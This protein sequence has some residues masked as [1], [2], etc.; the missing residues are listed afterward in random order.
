[1]GDYENPYI[2]TARFILDV[3]SGIFRIK[4]GVVTFP[5]F[6]LK[7][8]D[9]LDANYAEEV[10][11]LIKIRRYLSGHTQRWEIEQPITVIL[12]ES[13]KQITEG[14][15]VGCENVREVVLPEGSQLNRIGQQ[16]F[17]DSGLE[18]IN[19]D[20]SQVRIIRDVCFFGCKIAHITLP[21]SLVILENSVFQQCEDLEELVV[22]DS[23]KRIGDECFKECIFLSKID[24]SRTEVSRINEGCFSG[25]GLEEILLPE[26]LEYIHDGAFSE[27]HSLRSIEIPSNVRYI[28]TRVFSNC[29]MLETFKVTEEIAEADIDDSWADSE[30]LLEV[31][32]DMGLLSAK[33]ENLPVEIEQ[34]M[35]Y[36]RLAQLELPIGPDVS[37]GTC[38]VERVYEPDE[39]GGSQRIVHCDKIKKPVVFATLTGDEFE[40]NITTS[41]LNSSL[42]A[43]TVIQNQAAM[44]DS[45]KSNPTIPE[46]SVPDSWDMLLHTEDT[47]RQD[48]S[49]REFLDMAL[50]D[51]NFDYSEPIMIA[52]IGEQSPTGEP[53]QLV[54]TPTGGP[55]PVR[56]VAQSMDIG[57][58]PGN[59]T[60]IVTEATPTPPTPPT[61]HSP[62]MEE[63]TM[64]GKQR[65]RRTRK[66]HRNRRTRRKQNKRRSK[67]RR[68]RNTKRK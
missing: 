61:P 54:A 62:F 10:V 17:L 52:W 22:P 38:R 50:N 21:E 44:N 31:T 58:P 9:L 49:I 11:K 28:G 63:S 60:I 1:M 42:K 57:G 45:T 53:V 35:P 16:A 27:C 56:L 15:F 64:L 48:I 34:F 51:P 47:P 18:K 36:T 7:P 33:N 66:K 30:E 14:A 3:A 5:V 6:A 29:E 19:L 8:N 59:P 65:Q 4:P 46:L 12:S 26:S 43:I 55:A 23:L 40:V 24:L 41:N 13:V 32:I 20:K 39:E 37:Y 68:K 25:S 2:E 67:R